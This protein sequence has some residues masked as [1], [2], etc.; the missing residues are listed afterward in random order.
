[1]ADAPPPERLQFAQSLLQAGC[2][3]DG[4]AL[5][6]AR[7]EIADFPEHRLPCD[8]PPL[9]PHDP[10]AGRSVLLWHEQG[11]GDVIQML[12]FVPLLA[13][14]GARVMLAVQPP[15]KRLAASLDGVADIVS[16]GDTFAAP[17]YQ[18]PLL[19]LPHVLRI[20]LATLPA[21]VPYLQPPAACIEAWRQRLGPKRAPRIGVVWSG[22]PANRLDPWRS[23]PAAAL[24]PLLGLRGIEWHGLQDAIRAADEPALRGHPDMHSHGDALGD[25]AETA[26]LALQ[27]DAVV[28]VCTAMAHLAGALGLPGWVMLSTARRQPVAQRPRGLA[29]VPDAAAGAAVNAGR[30]AAGGGDGR[31]G[32]C[33]SPPPLAGRRAERRNEREHG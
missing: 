19:S 16:A 29:L 25:L 14:Q 20:R 15:L 11:L 32:G 26:A 13:R 28:S 3:R 2:F 4:W 6:E 33:G 30:L 17:D 23:M 31:R 24:Q 18:C 22:N 27:M 21:V 12:R 10:L 1:M 5:Y 8:A 7:R 9:R